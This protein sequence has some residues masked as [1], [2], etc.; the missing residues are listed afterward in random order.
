M[1]TTETTAGKSLFECFSGGKLAEFFGVNDDMQLENLT[2]WVKEQLFE[3]MF[4]KAEIKKEKILAINEKNP[5]IRYQKMTD[6][7]LDEFLNKAVYL[8]K[9]RVRM[10]ID[11]ENK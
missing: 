4:N 9:T 5:F 7:E 3:V 6:E 10:K 2:E 8:I 1:K 11:S